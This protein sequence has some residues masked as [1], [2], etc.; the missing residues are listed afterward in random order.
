ML[1]VVAAILL[2]PCAVAFI[3]LLVLEVGSALW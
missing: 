3:P 2:L 1:E